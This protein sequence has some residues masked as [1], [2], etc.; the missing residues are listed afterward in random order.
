MCVKAREPLVGVVLELARRNPAHLDA[1]V[2]CNSRI[3]LNPSAV[4]GDITAP[5]ATQLERFLSGTVSPAFLDAAEVALRTGVVEGEA[6]GDD[7]EDDGEL[8]EECWMENPTEVW[9]TIVTSAAQAAKGCVVTPG[10]Q[11]IGPLPIETWLNLHLPPT[12]ALL[13]RTVYDPAGQDGQ[14]SNVLTEAQRRG[15]QAA[16]EQLASRLAE[17]LDAIPGPQPVAR[18]LLVLHFWATTFQ[19]SPGERE[20]GMEA[21]LA[22]VTRLVEEEPGAEGHLELQTLAFIAGELAQQDADALARERKRR[23]EPEAANEWFGDEEDAEAHAEQILE[24]CVRACADAA[25]GT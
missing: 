23:H 8:L 14:D 6:N 22:A 16:V 21:A 18:L 17:S 25:A 10:G 24:V 20:A 4:G 7:M 3:F 19:L 9:A 5:L 12:L 15:Q 2:R 1:F 11:C 13:R